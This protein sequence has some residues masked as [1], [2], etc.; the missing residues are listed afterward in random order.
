MTTQATLSVEQVLSKVLNVSVDIITDD[1]GPE[2]V[3]SWDSF[4]ALLIVTELEKNFNVE[5]TIDEVIEVKK[6][7]DIKRILKKHLAS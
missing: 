2:H 5:F 4:N 7:A 3:S 1:T 6:V